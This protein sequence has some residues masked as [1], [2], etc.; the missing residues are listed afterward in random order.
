MRIL[1]FIEYCLFGVGILGIVA[2]KLFG[3]PTGITLGICL[4]GL[5]FGL[6]GLEA[7]ISRQMSL[8]FSDYGWDDWMGLPAVIVGLTQLLIS[9]ALIGSA[10]ALHFG[11]WPRLINF[12]STRPGPLLVGVGLLLFGIGLVIVIMADRYG[13]KLRF[14]F[15]GLPRIA[16]G[17]VTLVLGITIIGAGT[18]EW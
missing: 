17:V 4:V 16:I 1:A 3:L 14:I 5:G 18:W 8:R 13:G 11:F 15:V 10:Y 2:G 6:A 12:L 7:I 9:V